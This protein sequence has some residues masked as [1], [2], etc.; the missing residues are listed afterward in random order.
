MQWGLE[1]EGPETMGPDNER[2]DQVRAQRNMPG[3]TWGL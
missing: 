3:R 2:I 1:V